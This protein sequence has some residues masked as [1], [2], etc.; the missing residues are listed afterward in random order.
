MYHG[1]DGQAGIPPRARAGSRREI[2]PDCG[3]G[4]GAGTG[5]S[6]GAAALR[7]SGHRP[8]HR[9][10]RLSAPDSPLI[11]LQLLGP[12]TVRR[13]DRPEESLPALTRPRPL[14]VLI[15]LVLA[16][17]RGLHA[18]DTIVGLLW[19][20]V[21]QESARH[22]LRNAL[23]TIRTALG[24]G[25]VVTAGDALVGVDHAAISCDALE[26]AESLARGAGT[27]PPRAAGELLQGFH[28]ND[29]P[30]FEHWLDGE[31][32]RL[33][34]RVLGHAVA[35]AESCRARGDIAGA[36]AA[37]R[38]AVACAPED[39]PGA[40][41]LLGLLSDSGDRPGALQF[42]R[43]FA[44]RLRAEHDVEPSRETRAM[45][46][47]LRSAD[48]SFLSRPPVVGPAVM[49]VGPAIFPASPFAAPAAFPTT[50]PPAGRDRWWRMALAASLVLG[51]VAVT[52]ASGARGRP[53]A[54][55]APSA[56][57]YKVP[58]RYRSD[59]ALMQ[60]YLRAS[61]LLERSEP[62][63]RES[64]QRIV[65]Q[66]PLYAPAWASL[67]TALSLSGFTD[68]PPQVALTQGAAAADR[69]LRLDNSLVEADATLIGY[70]LSGAWDLA[71][72]KRR[73]DAAFVRHPR[74]PTLYTL[75]GSWHRWRGE[76][77][78]AV[79][80]DQ[81]AL[82]S[83]PLSPRL[84]QWLGG[85]LYL[86]HRCAEA[87]DVFRRGAVEF[88]NTATARILLYRALKCE[89]RMDEAAAALAD[90]LLATGDTALAATLQ[91]P[92]APG[93]RDSAIRSVIRVRLARYL[94]S[95]RSAWQ[96][97]L[98]A[99]QAY[100]ELR[101]ADSVM[102]WLDSMYVEHAMA[103]HKVPY[104]PAYDF[105]HGDPRFQAFLR[106]LPWHPRLEPPR[107][108]ELS[109]TTNLPF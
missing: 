54:A 84:A 48:E 107:G 3:G 105:M 82:A 87:A 62:S 45:V 4:G 12:V 99:V 66:S 91:P 6:Y 57:D 15:Y 9:G 37:A 46:D 97:A 96:P 1:T 2:L 74:D 58:P 60:R 70:D 95:R 77:D 31:R 71:G 28:L 72:A 83:D 53:P 78:L 11:R 43:E 38:L 61:L 30:E 73:L 109:A 41:R 92:L 55:A 69:A 103:L 63:A 86:A 29:A 27:V 75:L 36:L 68:M 26:L 34:D 13:T 49:P 89:G 23:H 33:R 80:A 51:A 39:E 42:Y 18:R 102:V 21:S 32:A 65:D 52:I 94:A 59:T 106:R 24:E 40:R 7:S 79:A 76:L 19:P 5:A 14:A 90:Y 104:D 50:S 85:D 67:S 47:R 8:R 98:P 44:A 100:A 101:M 56:L 88:R 20:E 16:R 64:L 81:R 22:A 10:R 93:R 17:P 35:H 108:A 25:V